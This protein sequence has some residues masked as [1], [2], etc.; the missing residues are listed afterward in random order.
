M[1]LSI[2]SHG[3]NSNESTTEVVEQWAKEERQKI[4]KPYPESQS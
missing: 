2:D 3:N 1:F 4:V